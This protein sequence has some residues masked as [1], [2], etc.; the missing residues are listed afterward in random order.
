M[1]GGVY[2]E[3]RQALQEAIAIADVEMGTYSNTQMLTVMQE[4][5]KTNVT[6][7]G[8]SLGVGLGG[9]IAAILG[10]ATPHAITAYPLAFL[11]VLA[12]APLAVGGGYFAWRYWRRLR[13]T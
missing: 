6:G 4:R 9:L 2:S 8:T 12:G 1:D 11:G 13:Q 3:Q 10:I 7:M 5:F